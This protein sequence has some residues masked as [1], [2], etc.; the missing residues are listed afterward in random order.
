MGGS[1]GESC[2]GVVRLQITYKAGSKAQKVG[3]WTGDGAVG[4][5][6]TVVPVALSVAAGPA[7]PATLT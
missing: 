6:L 2:P 1:C 7:V 5:G 4:R 3:D